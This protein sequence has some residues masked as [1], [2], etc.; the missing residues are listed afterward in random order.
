MA[1]FAVLASTPLFAAEQAHQPMQRS[2]LQN[3]LGRA[4]RT[5]DY[6]IPIVQTCINAQAKILSV[7]IVKS[8]GYPDLDNAALKIARNTKYSPARAVG[9]EAEEELR[10]VQG[11]I[12]D[13][14]RRSSAEEL[15]PPPVTSRT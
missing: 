12:R 4:G 15:A 11:E 13:Q 5:A 9:P 7:E 1:G 6:P 3:R 8:S 14:G 2:R 10:E